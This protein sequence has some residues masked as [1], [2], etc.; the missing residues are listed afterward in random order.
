MEAAKSKMDNW[1][2]ADSIVV[3]DKEDVYIIFLPTFPNKNTA[4]VGIV[5]VKNNNIEEDVYLNKGPLSQ[6]PTAIGIR[7]VLVAKLKTAGLESSI[8][9]SEL[10]LHKD[11]NPALNGKVK[12]PECSQI[13]SELKSELNIVGESLHEQLL[14]AAKNKL[15]TK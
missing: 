14:R 7:D 4:P 13:Q 3:K 10:N 12:V 5:R 11:V 6:D 2:Y 8:V 1:N 9:R 15:Q